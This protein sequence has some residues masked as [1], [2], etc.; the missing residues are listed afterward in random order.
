MIHLVVA[1]L[2]LYT[3][4]N[5]PFFLRGG[6]YIIHICNAAIW[7]WKSQPGPIKAASTAYGSMLLKLDSQFHCNIQVI[8]IAILYNC[9]DL[10]FFVEFKRVLLNVNQNPNGYS[11]R[12]SVV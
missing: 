6:N 1:V 7:F 10:I 8:C 3:A 11:D 5:A 4:T 2:T 12:K 9:M